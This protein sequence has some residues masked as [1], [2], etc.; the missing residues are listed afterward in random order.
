MSRHGIV[1][2]SYYHDTPGPLARSMKD[3]GILLD[4]MH[5]PDSHDN[6]TFEGIGRNP[7]NGYA[8][9]VTSKSSLSS[10]KLGIPWQA[11]WASNGVGERPSTILQHANNVSLACELTWQPSTVRDETVRASRSRR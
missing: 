3:V 7:P 11:Y 4:I 1:T 10:M 6:L 8:A 9:A 5:G 2:G